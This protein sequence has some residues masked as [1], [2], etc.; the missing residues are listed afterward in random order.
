MRSGAEAGARL[1][2]AGSGSKAWHLGSTAPLLYRV[3]NE[4]VSVTTVET[5]TIEW[6]RRGMWLGFY[7]RACISYG[8]EHAPRAKK[9]EAKTSE[10][11]SIRYGQGEDTSREV[12]K[13]PP[14]LTP[15]Q[16]KTG[17][18]SR[19]GVTVALQT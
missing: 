8:R 9:S 17:R 13:L 7:K 1:W 18:V 10:E 5:D 16:L 14:T 2:K 15:R 19:R 6:S 12:G 3:F 11:A 4:K